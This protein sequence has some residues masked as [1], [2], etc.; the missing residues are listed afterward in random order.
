MRVR[1]DTNPW[2]TLPQH[3]ALVSIGT[4]SLWASVS[5][6]MRKDGDPLL[7]FFTGAGGSTALYIKLQQALSSH[8]RCLFYDRAGYDRSTLPPLD[9]SQGKQI[10]AS[11]TSSDLTKLLAG[12]GLEPPYLLAAHSFGGILLRTFLQ[13]T[14]QNSVVTGV[15]LFDTATELMLS[16]LFPRVPPLS[17]TSIA[18]NVD[19]EALMHLQ[20]DSGMSDDEWEEAIQANGRC[21]HALSLEDTHRSAYQLS[22]H[23]QIDFQAFG[24]RP[25]TVVQCEVVS[26]YQLL[27]D[28][29][30][31]LGDG[32]AEEREEARAFIERWG[33]LHGQI[34]RAQKGLSED[35]R[36]VYFGEWG[37]DLVVRRPGIVVSEVRRLLER[38]GCGCGSREGVVRDHGDADTHVS[39]QCELIGVGNGFSPA[40]S[41]LG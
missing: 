16:P 21:I 17:L 24:D 5:G 26:D 3:S 15:L 22:L 35:G 20:R 37:H 23:R 30:V 13:S 10:L 34:A 2:L 7:I 40:M 4:H 9:E 38:M 39:G 31:K 33:A 25:L 19:L 29:G 12:T 8:I 11:H 36:F 27:Y 28:E 1:S 14:I 32:T 41:F 18:K 6:P